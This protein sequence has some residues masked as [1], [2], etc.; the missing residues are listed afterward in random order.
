MKTSYS[1]PKTPAAEFSDIARGMGLQTIRMQKS[2][3]RHP[4]FLV[5]RPG[6][7]AS[8]AVLIQYDGDPRVARMRLTQMMLTQ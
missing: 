1:A 8:D 6:Q 5:S 4:E 3:P 2:N 7:A